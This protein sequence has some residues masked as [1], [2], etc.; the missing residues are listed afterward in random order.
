[1][2]CFAKSAVVSPPASAAS[3][4]QGLSR[5]KAI[6]VLLAAER[7]SNKFPPNDSA[8]VELHQRIQEVLKAYPDL[9]SYP[10]RRYISPAARDNTYASYCAA[11]SRR[12]ERLGTADFPENAGQRLHGT[13][14][15]SLAI[16]SDGQLLSVEVVQSSGNPILDRK[17]VAIAQAA[18]PFDP[19][20]SAMRKKA[21]EIVMTTHF[22]FEGLGASSPQPSGL[23]KQE[24]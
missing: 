4:A 6:E 12:I 17:A 16:A 14:V 10:R 24:E 23:V 8:Q 5:E 9:A 18:G 11:V 21:D 2:S 1:M 20:G 22:R 19:F 7:K 13:L 3:A 15:V